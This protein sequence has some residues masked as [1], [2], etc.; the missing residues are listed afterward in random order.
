MILAASLSY[1]GVVVLKCSQTGK[2]ISAKVTDL[3]R[4]DMRPLQK[5][6]LKKGSSLLV[7]VKGMSYPAEILGFEGKCICIHVLL[8]CKV[9]VQTDHDIYGHVHEYIMENFCAMFAILWWCNECIAFLFPPEDLK[10]NKEAKNRQ[11]LKEVRKRNILDM[12]K[13][14]VWFALFAINAQSN[15]YCVQCIEMCLVHK[16][17]IYSVYSMKVVMSR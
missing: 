14:E 2:K 13:E 1:T 6:D 9:S 10:K 17:I 7:D 8:V 12:A 4:E 11:P 5:Q 15:I 3:S 16:N